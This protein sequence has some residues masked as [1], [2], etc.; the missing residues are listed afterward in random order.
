MTQN[1]DNIQNEIIISLL[2]AES[3]GRAIA[4]RLNLPH[5]SVQR[6]LIN[7]RKKNV[8][9]FKQEGKN[10]VY[11][12]KSTLIAKKQVYIAEHYRFTKLLER[13]PLL[14]PVIEDILKTANTN[15]IILFGSYAK[16]SAK[17]DSDID[18]YIETENNKIK[19]RV[20]SINSRI[21]VKI[22]KFDK[23]SLLIKEIIKNHII[24]KGIEEYY[25]KFSS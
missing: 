16:F 5:A 1:R 8:I 13:Y 3:H 6:A 20:E 11:F 15:L 10:K 17:K 9:D 21:N 24:I 18:I 7:L 4:E 14:S 25:G 23:N 19:S 12:I 2:R 22:G